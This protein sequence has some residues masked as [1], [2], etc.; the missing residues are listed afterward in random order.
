MRKI[1]VY[2]GTFN[3]PHNG[4]VKAVREAI[5]GLD[6]DMV[7]V[8][9]ALV[10]PHKQMSDSA[11]G[12]SERLEMTRLAFQDMEQVEVLDVEIK[13]NQTSYTV[14]TL[15]EL[16]ELYPDCEFWLIVGSDMFLSI[17]T[18]RS[19]EEIFAQCGICVLAR[20]QGDTEALTAHAEFL[21]DRY[22]A[23]SAVV[24]NDILELSSTEVRQ[25]LCTTTADGMIPPNVLSYIKTN[26]I[27]KCHELSEDN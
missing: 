8:I 26:G 1:G 6:L 13:R 3:P 20:A 17:Q 16:H 18:W 12:P 7:L 2:G 15:Y 9:P 5:A 25:A 22:G 11:P 24:G 10:P 23:L 21:H 27:Y 19:L 14:D 4:H